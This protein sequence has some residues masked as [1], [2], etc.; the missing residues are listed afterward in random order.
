MNKRVMAWC[1]T[2]LTLILLSDYFVILAV[3][4]HRVFGSFVAA[5]AVGITLPLLLGV[6]GTCME[7]RLKKLFFTPILSVL[8]LGAAVAV[9]INPP[10]GH[11]WFPSVDELMCAAFI[12]T[13]FITSAVI[14][15][16]SVVHAIITKKKRYE[17]FL[18]E[19]RRLFPEHRA[20]WA[21]LLAAVS[22]VSAAVYTVLIMGA[23]LNVWDTL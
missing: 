17:E 20:A 15:V 8:S 7:V 21:A 22:G 1:I 4:Y 3:L 19:S 12:S 2:A 10:P 18:A 14:L 23:H 5:G 6:T 13:C 11:M 9:Y 16:I